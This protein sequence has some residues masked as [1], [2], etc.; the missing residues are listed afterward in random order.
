MGIFIR[1]DYLDENNSTIRIVF[2]SFDNIDWTSF[3]LFLVRASFHPVNRVQLFVFLE[4][5]F[6]TRSFF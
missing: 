2:N 4:L 3:E 6:L 5:D 1:D